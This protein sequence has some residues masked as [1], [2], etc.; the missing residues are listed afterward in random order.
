MEFQDV[1]SYEDDES[2][3]TIYMEANKDKN[4]YFFKHIEDKTTG[5]EEVRRQSLKSFLLEFYLIEKFIK[6]NLVK[7]RE[8]FKQVMNIKT[9]KL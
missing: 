9:S 7:D 3:I 8:F 5:I 2:I 4:Y 1:T 6:G